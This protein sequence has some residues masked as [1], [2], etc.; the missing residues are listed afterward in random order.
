MT[1]MIMKSTATWMAFDHLAASPYAPAPG[2]RLRPTMPGLRG[3]G[4][5]LGGGNGES[6]AVAGSR[7]GQL[8]LRLADA[9]SG[10]RVTG[11]HAYRAAGLHAYRVAEFRP[12]ADA[13][14]AA[15][16]QGAFLAG[17]FVESPVP[18]QNVP[19]ITD[20]NEKQHSGPFVLRPPV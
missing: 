15:S 1:R 20:R 8:G 11:L 4:C 5:P 9:V 10:V 13:S 18:T 14:P 12:T 17:V 2:G 7:S 3:Q 6:A 16:S 19:T